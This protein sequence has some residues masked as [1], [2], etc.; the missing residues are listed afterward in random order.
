MQGNKAIAT[1]AVL[2]S[3]VLYAIGT[4]LTMPPA[5]KPA[6]APA[7]VFSAERAHNILADLLKEN[8][9]HPVGSPQN[10]IVK[11]RIMA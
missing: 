3:L 9:P 6:T 2:L 11:E 10:R 8:K 4:L 5:A 7:G 1:T